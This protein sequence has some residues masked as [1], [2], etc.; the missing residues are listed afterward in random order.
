[1]ALCDGRTV[2]LASR[3]DC[4]ACERSATQ[5]FRTVPCWPLVGLFELPLSRQ[6]PEKCGG[7]KNLRHIPHI[8]LLNTE[9]DLQP[10]TPKPDIS[11]MQ[12][13]H[14]LNKAMKR[15][16][17]FSLWPSFG[18]PFTPRFE[19]IRAGYVRKRLP[20][21]FRIVLLLALLGSGVGCVERPKSEASVDAPA[22]RRI[23]TS[24]MSKAEAQA[25]KGEA[26]GQLQPLIRRFDR[27]KKAYEISE[28][29]YLEKL[30]LWTLTFGMLELRSNPGTFAGDL[31]EHEVFPFSDFAESAENLLADLTVYLD[32]YAEDSDPEL[33]MLVQKK[34]EAG[35]AV[36]LSF[37][38]TGCSLRDAVVAMRGAEFQAV[39]NESNPKLAELGMIGGKHVVE[40]L[41]VAASRAINFLDAILKSQRK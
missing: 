4:T 1:M 7:V 5:G 12:I 23:D 26:L 10:S 14:H 20:H 29:Q 35:S 40:T 18:T 24:T 31:P 25:I 17:W 28:R 16:R 3:L 33:Q 11:A 19:T 41:G 39:V 6:T 34:N 30:Y 15:D 36:L 32:R 2:D 22:E 37:P 9:R 8:S 38:G 27:K 21:Y 13:V